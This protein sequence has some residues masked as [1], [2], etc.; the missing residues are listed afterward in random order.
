MSQTTTKRSIKNYILK[1]DTE[2]S[3]RIRMQFVSLVEKVVLPNILED[4][5]TKIFQHRNAT[6]EWTE[7]S[8][9]VDCFKMA[10]L[11]GDKEMVWMC[12]VPQLRHHWDTILAIYH[13]YRP[14]LYPSVNTVALYIY[15][16][17]EQAEVALGGYKNYND[18]IHT[19]LRK[20]AFAEGEIQGGRENWFLSNPT[21]TIHGMRRIQVLL[22]NG[23]T[24]AE[25]NREITKTRRCVNDKQEEYDKPLVED[26][27]LLE[28]KTVEEVMGFFKQ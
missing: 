22:A 27:V 20:I 10:M 12:L 13:L 24:G 8:P 21:R 25:K 6:E 19:Y 23:Y 28:K 18:D 16:Q 14:D 4:Y 7:R 2:N 15:T 1:R 9:F 11:P 3:Q 5:W 17:L 26:L